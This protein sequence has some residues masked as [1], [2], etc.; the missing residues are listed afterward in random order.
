M[1][2]KNEVASGDPVIF[3]EP[4]QQVIRSSINGDMYIDAPP[5]KPSKYARLQYA[6]LACGEFFRDEL[7]F[8]NIEVLSPR[9]AGY[10]K[11]LRDLCFDALDDP[12]IADAAA[13]KRKVS[14]DDVER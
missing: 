11:D 6:T 1:D 13:I 4:P 7:Q 5:L 3:R 2:K 8:G 14:V 12:S 10:M 9:V